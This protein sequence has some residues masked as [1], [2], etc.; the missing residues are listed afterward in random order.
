MTDVCHSL[1]AKKTFSE[2]YKTTKTMSALELTGQLN[3]GVG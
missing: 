1:Q 2:K 3:R